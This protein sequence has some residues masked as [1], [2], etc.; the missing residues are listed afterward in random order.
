[1]N[2]ALL[3]FDEHVFRKYNFLIK[4][5]FLFLLIMVLAIIQDLIFSKVRGTSFYIS[6]SLLY[7]SHWIFLIP[8]LWIHILI[9]SLFDFKKKW[10]KIVFSSLLSLIICFLH[11]TLF[12]S[13]FIGVS[14]LIYYQPH[15]FVV[16]F[17]GLIT[18]QLY[19]LLTIYLIA[20]YYYHY[21]RKNNGQNFL[22][23]Q[24][25]NRI[26][27]KSGTSTLLVDQDKI[28][29]II[30]NRPYSEIYTNEGK[31][32][33]TRSLREFEKMLDHESLVRIHKSSIINLNCVNKLESR[34][35]G[36]YDAH[37]SN[38]QKVR[39]SRHFRIFWESL[40]HSVN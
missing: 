38:G 8:I 31:F 4:S 32:L 19:L 16:I 22:R 18:R 29:S 36:D 20:P 17:N 6:E 14:N 27:V 34:G 21:L 2:K 25:S 33:D 5:S 10:K 30:S 23:E 28:I 12:T 1:M 3:Y 39:L 24:S 40:L 37:L 11:I 7:N 15:R 26:S 13:F 35:N 9:F